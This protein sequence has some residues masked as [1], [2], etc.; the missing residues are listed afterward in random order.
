MHT[1]TRRQLLG[2]GVAGVGA[3][4]ISGCQV[5]KGV[6]QPT[7]TPL[8]DPTILTRV[9]APKET[10]TKGTTVTNLNGNQAAILYVPIG[11]QPSTPSPFVLMLHGENEAAVSALEVFQPYADAAGLVLLAVDSSDTTWDIFAGGAY[12][13]DV[14][15]INAS[16]AATFNEVNVD[17]ARVTVEGFSDGGS[18]ALGMGLTNGALFSRV[19]SFSA[20]SIAPYAPAGPKPTF[21]MSQGT[22]DITFDI[23]Q[24]GDF[25]DSTLTAAGYSVDYVR[26]DGVHEIPDAIVQQALTWLAT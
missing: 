19:I 4:L 13:P 17:P 12:G 18:Y 26:F 9:T 25:I 8:T 2:M 1:F 14:A 22:G 23:T 5:F 24:S 11:Y 6:D 16:L 7:G 20:G 3:S 10:A 15:F 21:F